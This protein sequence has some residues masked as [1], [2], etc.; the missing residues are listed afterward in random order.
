[1]AVL[2]RDPAQL[3]A[4]R[5]LLL[6]VEAPR[7][8][9]ALLL[10]VRRPAAR[11]EIRNDDALLEKRRHSHHRSEAL[12]VHEVLA[13][14]PRRV[15]DAQPLERHHR[16]PAP[17]QADAFEVDVAVD[18]R[19]DLALEP[20]LAALRLDEEDRA[21]E[22]NDRKQQD[23]ENDDADDAERFHATSTMRLPDRG[24]DPLL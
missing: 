3:D 12:R 4:A 5:S 2:E 6:G 18:A 19:G 9:I 23:H 1:M 24:S 16:R 8:L 22:R 20:A 17:M 11:A 7:R 10:E 14:R 21:S 15:G 13:A